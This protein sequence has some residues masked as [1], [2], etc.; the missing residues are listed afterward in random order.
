MRNPTL[1]IMHIMILLVSVYIINAQ[2]SVAGF[3]YETDIHH[4]ESLVKKEWRHLFWMPAYNQPLITQMFKDRHP[5]DPAARTK[6]LY[7]S[8]LKE[9]TQVYGF[10]TYYFASQTTGH[11]ELLSIDKSYQGLGYGKKLLACAVDFFTD[12]QCSLL[13]LYVYTNNH[14]AIEFYKHQGFSVKRTFPGCLLLS[15]EIKGKSKER[16]S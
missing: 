12:H 13:Q 6:H 5:G 4:I 1:K 9:H 8:V 3:N 16:E 7:I 11:I 14:H 15:K 10:I 2:A